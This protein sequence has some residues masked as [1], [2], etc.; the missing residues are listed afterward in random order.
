MIIINLGIGFIIEGVDIWA[1]IG[2]LIGGV[3]ISMA[4]GVKY[5]SNTS[6]RVNGCI[7][8]SILVGFMV[9]LLLK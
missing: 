7:L 4:L 9:F 8:L 5:K 2:G 6:S 3:L 1:H